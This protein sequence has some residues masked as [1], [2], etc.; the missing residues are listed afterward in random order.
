MHVYEESSGGHKVIQLQQ[1]LNRL[2]SLHVAKIVKEFCGI[3]Q[4][5]L[6]R[7]QRLLRESS[8]TLHSCKVEGRV[9]PVQVKLCDNCFPGQPKNIIINVITVVIIITYRKKSNL[10]CGYQCD[11]LVSDLA[12]V[13][14]PHEFIEPLAPPTG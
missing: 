9:H 7:L 2:R 13:M 8:V 11:L 5:S 1:R 4:R 14:H 12:G 3:M 6:D 10:L